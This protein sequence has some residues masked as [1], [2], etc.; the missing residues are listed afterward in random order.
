MADRNTKAFEMFKESTHWIV[1]LSGVLETDSSREFLDKSRDF[2]NP[3]LDVVFNCSE[4]SELSVTWIRAMLQLRGSLKAVNKQLRL[5]NV[6]PAVKQALHSEGVDSSLKISPNLHASLLEMGAV[7]AT[8]VMDVNF[9]NP[10]LVATVNVLKT[11]ASTEATSG[12]IFKKDANATFSGD[13][14]GVIGLVSDAF[15]GSVVISFPEKTFLKI[16]SRMIGEE[17]LEMNKDIADGA[18]ELTNIIFGQ[19]K[20]ALNERGFG[21][22]TALPSVISG[23]EHSVQQISK[24]PM[25]VIPFETDAGPFFVEI[26]VSE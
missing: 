16:I 9:I 12:K 11:Q 6:T 14:S 8:K 7:T 13:I 4:L 2:F 26:C 22:K 23:A 5:I 25:M 15:S 21:I 24:G 3:P 1:K 19:A 18:G 20:V 17:C 10:F